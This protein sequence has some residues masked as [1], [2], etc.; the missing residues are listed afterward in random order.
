MARTYYVEVFNGFLKYSYDTT[1][2]S[3]LREAKA[4]AKG[5]LTDLQSAY[6]DLKV[7]EDADA[8]EKA[9]DISVTVYETRKTDCDVDVKFYV[10]A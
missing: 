3:S 5:I 8:D 4:T 9:Y 6:P 10:L 1:L 7:Y 2:F